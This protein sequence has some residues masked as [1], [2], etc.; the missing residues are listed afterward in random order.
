MNTKNSNNNK[1]NKKKIIRRIQGIRRIR[2]NMNYLFNY[3]TT[4]F[5]K[6]FKNYSF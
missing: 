6:N 2:K 4:C 3:E 5:I 1:K